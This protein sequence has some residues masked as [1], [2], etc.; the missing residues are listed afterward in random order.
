MLPDWKKYHII[1]LGYIALALNESEIRELDLNSI[2]T[3]AALSQQTEWTP[4]QVSVVVNLLL[5]KG[6]K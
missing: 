1:S 2:D 5:V 3:V 6:P 4:D